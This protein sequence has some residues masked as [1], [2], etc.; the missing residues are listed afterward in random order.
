[1]QTPT[2][3]QTVAYLFIFLFKYCPDTRLV[4]LVIG[5]YNHKW[6]NGRKS[7]KRQVTYS[8]KCYVLQY[9]YIYIY[10]VCMSDVPVSVTG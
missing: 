3:L 5:R 4:R 2:G 8:S 7:L 9:I 6:L 10:T 1:M